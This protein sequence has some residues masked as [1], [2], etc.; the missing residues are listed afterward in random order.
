MNFFE[1]AAGVI[2]ALFVAAIVV[3]FL[4]VEVLAGG[5]KRMDGNWHEPPPRDDD[6]GP[7]RWPGN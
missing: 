7:A 3:G 1:I 5:P 4:I 2:G 6:G